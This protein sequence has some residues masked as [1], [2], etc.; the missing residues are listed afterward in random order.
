MQKMYTPARI[1]VLFAVLAIAMT[2]YVSALYYFQLHDPYSADDIQTPPRLITRRT[3]L[4]AARG[5]I[6][7]RNGV[8][9][10][11]GRPSYN[12]KLDWWVIRRSPT[13]NETVLELVYAV[14]DEGLT[15]TDTFP[16]TRG[17]P[18]EFVTNMTS[19]Q[20]NRLEAYL[21]FHNL[22]P[23]ISVSELLAWMRAH[24]RI[25]YTVGILDARLIIGIRYELEI[26]AIVGTISP[27]IFA[28]DVGTEFVAYIEERGL[29][30][31]HI[32]S[33]FVREYHTASAAH[34]LGYTGAM[35]AEEYEIYRLRDYPMDAIVGKVGAEFAFEEH[36]HGVSGEQ[37]TRM[38]EDGTVVSH[39]VTVYPI[40]GEHITLTI[41]LDLQIAVEN[42]LRTQIERINHERQQMRE[43]LRDDEEMELIPGGAVVVTDVNTGEILAAA[44][45]PTFNVSTLS[46]N[47]AFLNADPAFPMLNRAT[48]GR[49]SPGSTFKMVTAL[50]AL[51]HVGVI[52]RYFPIYDTGI[53]DAYEHADFVV[54][55]WIFRE[56]WAGHGY[57]DIVQALECSC[58]FYFLQVSDWLPGGAR[59]GAYLLAEAAQELGLGISTGL[60]MPE[61]VG[62]LAT[63]EV[64]A[65]LRPDE[66]WYSADLLLAGFG[67]GESRF[68]PVQLANYAATI[69][70][71]GTLYAL[72]ILQSIR[73]SDF[74]EVLFTQ[75]PTVLNVIE[76]TDYIEIIQEGMVAAS[77][78]GRGT[79]RA[80]FRNYPIVVASKTG[81]VQVEG[82]AM[83]DGVFVCYAPADD[84]QIAISIVVEKGGSGS[85][86]MD[87]ARIIFDH[88]FVTEDTF[89][90]TPYGG[91]IP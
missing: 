53:F 79:A 43:N 24:Y 51:R 6:Y 63:P 89:L 49:Y 76:E 87:I 21:E 20:R 10:A 32:E 73:S 57:V 59:P 56:N 18:F 16:V 14:M 30:G 3:T 82:R 39:E 1:G 26:R 66:G 5:N 33:S 12:I 19:V 48:Q 8:L 46:E 31:V 17:A 4:V 13:A 70:N 9:L 45:F 67:Q 85:A 40:P 7:D 52:S 27:Y 37:I 42:A 71:G 44:S 64:K 36:L 62:R 61:S 78:G 50:T 41:D 77:R 81:T 47:W 60:E 28:T 80:V 25:D 2:V 15:Y 35:T 74:T 75:T 88:Y 84:P 83:N 65:Q 22:D 58:N 38:T 23:E 54:H 55:C 72:S 90:A 86:I 29:H 34:L 91:M 69:A 68:T 11:S